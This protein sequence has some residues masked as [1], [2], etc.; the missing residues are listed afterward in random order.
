[1][2]LLFVAIPDS[3][4][5]AGWVR[6]LGGRGWD[7]H[8]FPTNAAPPHAA[9][10]GVTLHAF[11]RARPKGADPGLRVKG[12]Y[13]LRVGGYMSY[14]AAQRAFPR[15]MARGERLASLVKRIKPDIIHSLG[16]QLAGYVTL[17]AKRALGGGFP[18]WLVSCWGND[19]YLFGRLAEHAPKVGAVLSECDYF[20][21]D[22]ERDN[23]LARGQGFEGE[24]FPALPVIGGFD[25][26]RVR[27]LRTAVPPSRRRV[28]A[29]KGYQHWSG[30]ALDGLR[31]IESC[32]DVL[33]DYRV[34]LYLAD[35]DV[36]V[37]AELMSRRTGIPVEIFPRS[38][39]EET[40]GMHARARVSL[41]VSISD[42]LALSAMEAAMMGSFPIQTD[43][44]CV[45]ERLRD[46]VGTFLVPPDDVGRIADALRRAVTDDE[47]VDRA[48][49]TNFRH[50]AETLSQ[51]VVRPDVIAMYE[52]IHSARS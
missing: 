2:R 10:T 23:E 47:L 32:A 34:V 14:L 12:P 21:A 38:S 31:A 35:Y 50:I 9:L 3:V 8:L 11:S 24:T 43:T 29:L 16:V 41:G 45:G 19:L 5:T 52:K 1:L 44:S 6:Q 25:I 30:R 37:A 28:I 17:E 42:G 20:T 33:R 40:L 26:E 36:R 22:C 13:P 48:A 49:E 4:H 7:V 15:R 51:E 18:P 46:G 39:Y 27:G